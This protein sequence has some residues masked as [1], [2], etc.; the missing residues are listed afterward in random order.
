MYICKVGRY[1]SRVRG[2]RKN[3]SSSVSIEIEKDDPSGLEEIDQQLRFLERQITMKPGAKGDLDNLRE[4]G[5]PIESMVRLLAET[6]LHLNDQ[7]RFGQMRNRQDELEGL[8]NRLTA[9][10]TRLGEAREDPLMT[11]RGWAY[12][13]AYRSLGMHRPS[14]WEDDIG[15][16]QMQ[17][18]MLLLAKMFRGEAR[19]FG[20][21]LRAFG[22]RDSQTRV[23]LMLVSVFLFQREQKSIRIPDRLDALARLLNEAIT[24]AGIDKY[25]KPRRFT[26]NQSKKTGEA[27]RRRWTAPRGEFYTSGGLRKV[28]RKTGKRLL[29]AWVNF[30]ERKPTSR[31]V[32]KL[33]STGLLG[34]LGTLPRPK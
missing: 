13:M 23:G 34:T 32:P 27:Q 12:L 17:R 22:R 29:A 6:V 33:V 18:S 8:A 30:H 24:V 26:N 10:G 16:S 5:V 3:I 15:I 14:K 2:V 1:T 28:W 19:K 9:L 21:F 31:A 25:G 4:S 20:S 11:V 7:E